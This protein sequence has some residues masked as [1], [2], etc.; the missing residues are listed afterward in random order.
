MLLLIHA[1]S[2]ACLTAQCVAVLAVIRR[3]AGVPPF[4]PGDVDLHYPHHMIPW[5][6]SIAEFELRDS[7]YSVNAPAAVAA[8]LALSSALQ[9]YNGWYLGRNGPDAPRIVPCLESALAS[10]LAVLAVA[11]GAA[12]IVDLVACVALTALVFGA[13]VLAAVAELMAYARGAWALPHLGAWALLV[14][15]WLPIVARL[16]QNSLCSPR[17]APWFAAVCVEAALFAFQGVLQLAVLCGG[18][19]STVFDLGALVLDFAAKTVL[20]AWVIVAG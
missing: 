9:L 19:G 7:Q 2:A 10:P 20:A 13:G 18:R 16:Y 6:A 17:Q 1:A 4:V 12:G 14:C 15:A 3:R 8:S 11:V 5:N